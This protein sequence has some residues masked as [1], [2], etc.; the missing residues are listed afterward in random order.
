[1]VV[2]HGVDGS[3]LETKLLENTILKIGSLLQVGT[4]R[5]GRGEREGK[6]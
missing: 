6:Q 2:L 5:E 3:Q 4:E 1:M